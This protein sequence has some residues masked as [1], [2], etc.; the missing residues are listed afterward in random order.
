[1]TAWNR[2]CRLLWKLTSKKVNNQVNDHRSYIRN[3]SSCEKK[4]WKKFRLERDSNPWPL[5]Y[6]CSALP[7]EPSSQLGAGHCVNSLYTRWGDEMKLNIW[8]FRYLNCRRKYNQV[9]DHRKKKT[10]NN[11]PALWTRE[12][13]FRN[14][15][16]KDLKTNPVVSGSSR[17][18]ESSSA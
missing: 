2:A 6:R 14:V 13:V 17:S 16:W 12:G 11:N 3:L 4:A 1:M 10:N 5:R 15:A 8:K 9:N 18:S 7:I